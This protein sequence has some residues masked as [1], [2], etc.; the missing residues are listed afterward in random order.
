MFVVYLVEVVELRGQVL[1]QLHLL[2]DP[3]LGAVAH[4]L[5]GVAAALELFPSGQVLA[6]KYVLLVVPPRPVEHGALPRI[7]VPLHYLLVSHIDDC[8]LVVVLR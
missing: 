5:V 3:E 4:V 6:Q 1:A 8:F 7:P 2:G